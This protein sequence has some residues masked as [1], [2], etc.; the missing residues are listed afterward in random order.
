MGEENMRE[1]KCPCCGGAIE[2]NTK[3]QKMKCPFCDTEFEMETLQSYDEILKKETDKADDMQWKANQQE[4][5]EDE[6]TGLRTYVCSSCGGEI[7]GDANLAATAC[8][9]CDSPV[10][11]MSQFKG[12]L[13]PDYVIPFKLNKNEAKEG[14]RKHL[15]NKKLLPKAFKDENHID[16]IKGIYVPYWLFNTD[17]DAHI[18]FRA[19][20]TRS[21]SDSK[22]IYTETSHYSVLR[23]GSLGFDRVPADGSTKMADDLMESLEPYNFKEAMSFQTAY[24]SGFLADKY[25]LTSEEVQP[26]ANERIKKST[27]DVF[28]NTVTGFSTVTTENSQIT[29]SNA[30]IKYALYPVWI[31]NTTWKG[32]KY[33]FAMNGQTGKFVGNLPCD[34]AAATRWFFGLC[35]IIS[36]AT[37]GLLTL[38]N[39]L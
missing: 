33:V 14:Y 1:Y 6:E 38:L 29:L 39:L 26:R 20:K 3:L 36:A 15:L 21:W 10:I 9:Y 2:F 24:L 27:S 31:M 7:I 5:I 17:A 11:M 25:D 13:L 37:F 8:P 32:Q 12:E 28:K 34:K 19:T 18:R 30:E 35:G 23:D 4:W 16:E 22:Y